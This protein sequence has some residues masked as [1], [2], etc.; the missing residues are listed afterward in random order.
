MKKIL[1]TIILFVIMFIGTISV[2][3]IPTINYEFGKYVDYI[4]NQD[5][6]ILDIFNN[7]R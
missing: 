6:K 1:K 4:D 5:G 7:S 2:K 3:A